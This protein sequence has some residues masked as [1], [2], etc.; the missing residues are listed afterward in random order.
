MHRSLKWS[1]R[2]IPG[3][4]HCLRFQFA[5]FVLH[6]QYILLFHFTTLTIS[7]RSLGKR[8]GYGAALLVGRSR[9]RFPVVTGF[10]SDISP[11]DRTMALGSTQPLV[12]MS[13]RSIPGGKGGRCVRLTTSPPLRAECHEIWEPTPPGTLWATPGLLRDSF[14]L[15]F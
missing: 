11:S 2:L 15:P 8:S 6:V 7:G 9:D 5:S 10:F 1:L 3:L 12:K 4:K 14:T 13:T